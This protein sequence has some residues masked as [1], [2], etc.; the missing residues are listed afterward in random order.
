MCCSQPF[1]NGLIEAVLSVSLVV[2]PHINELLSTF[3]LA[4]AGFHSCSL[5]GCFGSRLPI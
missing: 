1:P 5:L 2:A 4:S 3:S